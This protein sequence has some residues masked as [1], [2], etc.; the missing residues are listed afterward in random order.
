MRFPAD[1]GWPAT[2]VVKRR[3]LEIA[4]VAGGDKMCPR[5]RSVNENLFALATLERLRT[6]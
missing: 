5:W 6:L 4:N 3:R 2:T 1:G